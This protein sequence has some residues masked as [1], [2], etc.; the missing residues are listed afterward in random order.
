MQKIEY[1]DGELYCSDNLELMRSMPDD[2]VDLVFGSPPY[3]AQRTY[4]E[5]DFK[6]KGEAWVSWMFELW[7]EM[8]RVSKGL[9][10]M[11]IEGYTKDFSYSASPI[12]LAADL[13]R[14]GFKLRKP[15]IYQRDGIPGS[16][17]PDWL[18]NDYE[19]VI[20]TSKGRLPWAD[21]TACGHPPAYRP[22]GDCTNR[23]KQ[24]NRSGGGAFRW[25]AAS[26]EI[27]S[28]EWKQPEVANPGNVIDCG[29]AG[30]GKMG[31]DIAHEGDAPFPEYLAEFMIRSFCPP[32]GIVLDPFA[33]TGTTI[34]VARQHRR[35]W[36]G[37]DI[38]PSEVE[39]CQRRLI[40][41]GTR[42]GFDLTPLP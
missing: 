38:R 27:T 12:L 10:A 13:K 2:S 23:D 15:P 5:L 18:R 30:G 34:S 16:G 7:S 11:V 4:R 14:A 17:G 28:K 19:F 35:R 6:L 3:E 33:G 40:N 9:V 21:N 42:Q 25:R 29:A 22:G 39:K 32:G 36:I 26:G 20:S 8:Q 41:A 1:E 24:G 37:C 31:C